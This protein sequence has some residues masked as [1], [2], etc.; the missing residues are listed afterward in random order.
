MNVTNYLNGVHPPSWNVDQLIKDTVIMLQTCVET[1]ISH[2]YQE[3]NSL[4]D[5]FTNV[6]VNLSKFRLWEEGSII[7]ENARNILRINGVE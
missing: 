7:P 2:V 5:C 3:G 6:V 4:V 1:R